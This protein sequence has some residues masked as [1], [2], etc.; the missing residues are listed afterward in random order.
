MTARAWTRS[1]VRRTLSDGRSTRTV[2][3]CP[4]ASRR[5]SRSVPRHRA[6]QKLTP[7]RSSTSTRE[8]SS[9]SLRADS[10]RSGAVSPS[11]S[12]TTSSTATPVEGRRVRRSN[13]STTPCAADGEHRSVMALQSG[14]S[15]EDPTQL[16]AASSLPARA[17]A[18]PP[19]IPGLPRTC[20]ARIRR[21]WSS[22]GCGWA[23]TRP[24]SVRSAPRRGP[25]PP[26]RPAKPCRDGRVRRPAP[27]EPPRHRH[28]PLPR[29][30]RTEARRLT[31]GELSPVRC[32]WRSRCVPRPA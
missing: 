8:P 11:T 1:A 28:P 32:R 14:G 15:D 2:A 30:A 3:P 6:E 19:A 27:R 10:S 22:S 29:R 17:P 5:I 16:E 21:R 7:A 24:T 26:R 4:S 18:R 9:S 13:S 12:P 25:R 20:S 23:R 31:G